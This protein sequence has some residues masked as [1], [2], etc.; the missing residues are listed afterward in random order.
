MGY[1]HFL[2]RS[3]LSLIAGQAMIERGL[4]PEFSRA[5]LQELKAI[6]HAGQDI[7]PRVVDMTAWLWCSIDNDD[8]RD[9]DQLT[10]AEKQADGQTKV[11]VAVA[12]VDVLVPKSSA[13][14][15]HAKHNTTSVYTS[16]RIFPMLPDRLCTDLTSLNPHQER[17]A[18]VVEMCINANA[19]V[20]HSQLYRAKVHN[21]AKLAYDAISDWIEGDEALP[22]PAQA[23]HGMAE[24]LLLQDAVA[25]S[26]RARRHAHGSLEFETLQPHAVFEGERVVAIRQQ[27]QNRARQLIEEFMIAANTCTAQF[28]AH[29]GHASLRRVV[30]SPERWQRIVALAATYDEHLPPEPDSS[31]LETFLAKRHKADPVRFPD[32]SLIVVKLMGSGEYVVERANSEAIGH[33]G[34]SVR[35]YT[36]STAPNRRYPDLVTQRMIKSVLMGAPAPYSSA[37][38]ESLALHCTQQE[39]AARKV[40]RRMRKSES[41]LM[42]AGHIGQVFEAVVTGKTSS[43]TW[44]RVFSPPVEGMLTSY[45]SDHEVGELLRVKLI[46]TN[47]EQGFIDFAAWG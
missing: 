33:F 11:W 19:E 2:G 8:S 44:V 6:A 24:Q 36:H 43:G 46:H 23:V 42:L 31:A 13:L 37:E 29:H 34:L 26:L 45:T 39:D 12:D 22:D 16:T 17:L 18:V 38:L 25:Q 41:A 15:A 20:T 30:R 14:D 3:D 4:E 5:A 21:K 35:D 47:V 32:L 10:V 1:K 28:L 7:D 27:V 40:E 9:L